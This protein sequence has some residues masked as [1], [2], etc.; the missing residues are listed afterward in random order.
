MS[1]IVHVLT[2]LRVGGAERFVLDLA[3]VQMDKMDEV[4]VFSCSPKKEALVSEAA[5]VGCDLILSTG[6][7]IKDYLIFFS[8]FVTKKSN[9]FQLHS[10]WALR[11]F[12]LL[13]P[14]LVLLRVKVIYTRHGLNTLPG[15]KWSLVHAFARPWIHKVSFVS[16]SGLDV[17]RKRFNWPLEKLVTIRNGVFVPKYTGAEGVEKVRLGSVGRMVELKGQK[18]LIEAMGA[19]D[20]EVME[21]LELHFF[22][23]G[24]ELD[25]LKKLSSKKLTLNQ[26]HF[27]GMEL[28]REKVYENIDVLVVCSEQE[29]LS[30][31]IMEAMARKIPVIST[32]V[33]DSPLLVID[34]LTGFL[35]GYN[36]VKKLVSLIEFIS[37]NPRLRKDLGN[38][39]RQH[40]IDN[41]S[42]QV[43]NDLYQE[44][45]MM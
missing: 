36:D 39:A 35:Y 1:N 4:T 19:S 6:S 21:K 33:G 17:F 44:N 22:G 18:H 15:V 30:L 14:V 11:Y 23:D 28:N 43:T 5:E 42:L 16:H 20:A 25:S 24:P 40:M 8:F 41:F 38:A 32:R 26:I 2:S 31:A 27:H 12:L 29:G 13:L 45:Y 10:P 3:Q 9:V 7:R 37:R 34:G